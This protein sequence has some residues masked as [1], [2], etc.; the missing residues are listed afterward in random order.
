MYQL[1]TE[2]QFEKCRKPEKY[3]KLLFSLAFFHSVLIERRKFGMLG[4]N[5]MYGFNDSDFEVCQQCMSRA[6]YA[7]TSVDFRFLRIYS[8]SIL[9]SMRRLSGKD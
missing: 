3:K 7:L 5:V 6:V 2:E 8:A 1:V 4:W 9:M